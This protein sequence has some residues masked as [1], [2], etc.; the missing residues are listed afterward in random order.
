MTGLSCLAG[1]AVL[2]V[3]AVAQ[4]LV[5]MAPPKFA[6]RTNPFEGSEIARSAG[7][8]LFMRECAAC[9]GEN[10]EGRKRAPS[11]RRPEVS[12]ASP[13]ALFWVLTNGSLCKGMP[14]FAHLPELQRWQ[15]V[16][17]LR[18]LSDTRP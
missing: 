8:K 9:H 12:H 18:G 3:C 5:Q 16:I 17:F 2:A 4:S 1:I 10:A 7:A 14:S 13:G 15:I 6:N 11:L